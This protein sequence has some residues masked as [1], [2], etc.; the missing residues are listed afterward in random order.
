MHFWFEN[1]VKMYGIQTT[2]FVIVSFGLFEND[3]KM[4]GIQTDTDRRYGGSSFE[5]DV[6]MYGIQTIP[7]CKIFASGLRMM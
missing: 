4:Y 2:L 6:K 1:D 7:P 5:N 3:V